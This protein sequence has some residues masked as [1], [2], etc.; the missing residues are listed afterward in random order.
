[1][2]MQPAAFI[3]TAAMNAAQAAA[4]SP[5]LQQAPKLPVTVWVGAEERPV[6]LD[7]ARWLV[8][9]WQTDLGQTDPG[10]VISAG[11]HHFNVI[12]DMVYPQSALTQ[13]FFA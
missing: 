9:A 7:Q 2:N 4:E 10:H 5:V 12:E 1:M 3:M 6:F 11:Q 13:A 8:E